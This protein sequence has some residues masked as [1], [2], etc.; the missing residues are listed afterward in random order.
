MLK[1]IILLTSVLLLLFT[2]KAY[3]QEEQISIYVDGKA[4]EY[5]TEGPLLRDD[6]T[7]VPI[8]LVS[9]NL[10]LN[11]SWNEIDKS[12]SLNSPSLKI[13]MKVDDKKYTINNY[14]KDM[15]VAPFIENSRAFVPIRFVSEALGKTVSWN[16]DTRS[17][18]I[19]DK[20]FVGNDSLDKYLDKNKVF[21]SF[22]TE[23]IGATPPRLEYANENYSV[24]LNYNGILI[25]E[26]KSGK[27]KAAIDNRELGY[28]QMQGDDYVSVLGND[29]DFLFL[30]KNSSK[31]SGYVYSIKDNK[32][33]YYEDVS[34][35][36]FKNSK[37][38]T[39]EE[40]KEILDKAGKEENFSYS[41][42]KFDN[43]ISYLEVN[44]NDIALS[45]L[46]ILN[47]NL[48]EIVTFKLASIIK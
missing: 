35:F 26:N 10:G 44:L 39:T 13:F 45:K 32:I 30:N 18:Y 36:N 29:K 47:K 40:E 4:I 6:R 31:K 1:K 46:T 23:K 9:E 41:M 15:D 11:V 22:V 8:R 33:K 43:G 48:K 25:I 34:T 3:C 17:I 5:E 14:K 24:I 27:I 2:N 28:S 37:N 7:F 16:G 19:D 20:N 21:K 12:I 42:I 38:V